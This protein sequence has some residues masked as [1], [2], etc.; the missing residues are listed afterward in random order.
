M[1][2]IFLILNLSFLCFGCSFYGNITRSKKIE[3]LIDSRQIEYN[4]SFTEATKQKIFGNYNQAINLFY[5]CSII[6][7]YSAAVYYQLSDIFSI[8]G[9]KNNALYFAR[10]AVKLDKKNNWYLLHLAHVYQLSEKI[11]STIYIYKKIVKANP[12]KYENQFN[13]SLL[14]VRNNQFNTAIRLLKKLR[15]NYGFNKEIAVTLYKIYEIRNANKNAIKILLEAITKYPEE[16]HFYGLLAEHYAS[17]GENK[18]ALEYYDKLLSIDPENQKGILS[19]FEFYR[20]IPDYGRTLETAKKIISNDNFQKDVKIETINTLL[21]DKFYLNRNKKQLKEVIEILLNGNPTDAKAHSLFAEYYVKIDSLERAKD[22]YLW[23]IKN[24]KVNYE[25]WE[26]LFNVLISLEDYDTLFK[27]SKDA[28]SNFGEKSGIYLFKGMAAYQLKK[29]DD[30]LDALNIGLKYVNDSK[31]VELQ[32]FTFLGE[33][34]NALKDFKNSDLFFEKALDVD[35]LNIFVLNNYSFYLAERKEK[36]DT[37]LEYSRKCL[38]IQPNNYK[39]LDTYGWVLYKS[40]RYDEAKLVFEGSI[41]KGGSEN[42]DILVHYILVLIKLN[43][44]DDALR[45]YHVL[46]KLGKDNQEIRSLLRITD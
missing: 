22:E 11:D 37:A 36:L 9:D 19:L 38:E 24:I 17:L 16:A 15:K 39:Y 7:P 4:Y 10:L 40:E 44:L 23:I 43:L 27:L 34:Y 42:E 20:N 25:E 6:S 30:A 41:H 45:N 32:F 35:K 13:F 12:N 29:Y 21:N 28:I 1:Y 8:I 2:R 14:Y 26:K 31:I 33:T 5:R 3:P 46:K 18:L